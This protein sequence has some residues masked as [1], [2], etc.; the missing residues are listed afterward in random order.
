MGSLST[1]AFIALGAMIV[2]VLGIVATTII[3]IA[4]YNAEIKKSYYEKI[5][6]CAY[7]EWEWKAK[8]VA[9]PEANINSKVI[10]PFNIYLYFYHCFFKLI[11]KKKLNE[12]RIKKFF[13]NYHKIE[14]ALK[15]YGK[16]RTK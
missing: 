11:N 4:K 13:E 3:S 9:N 5:I 1:E 16:R 7:K 2:G 10:L 12:E 8:E 14:D 15:E 6:D